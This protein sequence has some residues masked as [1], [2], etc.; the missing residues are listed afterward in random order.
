MPLEFW[1]CFCPSLPST[2][3]NKVKL[4]S[5]R[6]QKAAF[7]SVSRRSSTFP[8]VIRSRLSGNEGCL[9]DKCL[10]MITKP[11]LGKAS[12]VF[13]FQKEQIQLRLWCVSC[14]ETIVPVVCGL[15]RWSTSQICPGV[16]AQ[17]PLELHQEPE[18][19]STHLQTVPL[20]WQ[21]C[22]SPT[23]VSRCSQSQQ[24]LSQISNSAHQSQ[25]SW[26]RVRSTFAR[27]ELHPLQM[28]YTFLQWCWVN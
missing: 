25:G 24:F 27:V 9:A 26:R 19:Q 1:L 21:R 12:K 6:A 16:S 18:Q 20:G 2:N 15:S 4:C 13:S 10:V 23:L 14:M 8:G 28:K 17:K 11:R 7:L 5:R 3:Q 22:H